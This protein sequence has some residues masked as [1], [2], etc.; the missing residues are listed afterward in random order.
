MYVAVGTMAE[1]ISDI[2]VTS[3][4][5]NRFWEIEMCHWHQHVSNGRNKNFGDYSGIHKI[6]VEIHPEISNNGYISVMM[7]T[8]PTH[9]HGQN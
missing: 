7:M 1:I 6:N 5:K 3:L 9:N 2:C 4:L 8:A